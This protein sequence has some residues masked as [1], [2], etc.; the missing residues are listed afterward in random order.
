MFIEGL[1]SV[2]EGHTSLCVGRACFILWGQGMLH[3]V[4][5]GHASFSVGIACFIF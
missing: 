2:G 1:H 5:A 4:G 3:S